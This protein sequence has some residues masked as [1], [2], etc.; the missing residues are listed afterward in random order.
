MINCEPPHSPTLPPYALYFALRK[1][2]RYLAR[3]V[4]KAPPA[5]LKL[6]F[7]HDPMTHREAK[8]RHDIAWMQAASTD[9]LTE[10]PLQRDGH[11]DH[12]DLRPWLSAMLPTTSKPGLNSSRTPPSP[13]ASPKPM[14]SAPYPPSRDP[15]PSSPRTI[16]S[17]MATDIRPCRGPSI[18]GGRPRSSTSPCHPA[19]AP[20]PIS[21]RT[22]T[23]AARA[24]SPHPQTP[25]LA[26]TNLTFYLHLL[27]SRLS[28]RAPTL[29]RICR[30]LY[31]CREGT[32]FHEFVGNSGTT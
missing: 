27:R 29:L 26:C 15:L 3:L 2:L 13:T 21:Q 19:V 17:R 6:I 4:T 22:P 5:L 11:N 10:L 8:I 25:Q 14:A 20:P 24:P 18:R 9:N 23:T 32:N 28:T 7:H 16:S 30:I 12:D 31:L 1:R